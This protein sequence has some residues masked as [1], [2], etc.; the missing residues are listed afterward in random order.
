M[1]ITHDIML[2]RVS[3]W[4]QKVYTYATV[5]KTVRAIDNIG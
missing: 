3:A 2:E 4:L 5:D 1:S